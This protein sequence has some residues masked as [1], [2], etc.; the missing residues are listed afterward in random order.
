[1][2]EI[3]VERQ[4]SE[5]KAGRI[6]EANAIAA[7]KK[8]LAESERYLAAQEIVSLIGGRTTPFF[9]IRRET[10]SIEVLVFR[11]DAGKISQKSPVKNTREVS[12]PGK[13]R[14]DT[15][16]Q[17]LGEFMGLDGGKAD[18]LI[19]Y[20]NSFDDKE[21]KGVR[22]TG[23]KVKTGKD[24]EVGSYLKLTMDHPVNVMGTVDDCLPIRGSYRISGQFMLD[25]PKKTYNG[26]ILH[27]GQGQR[28]GGEV[29]GSAKEGVWQTFSIES[30]ALSPTDRMLVYFSR[31][32]AKTGQQGLGDSLLFADLKVEILDR[33]SFV[34]RKFSPEGEVDRTEEEASAQPL[35]FEDRKIL[36]V[37]KDND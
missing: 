15:D 30:K 33:R 11:D 31:D 3:L 34:V 8:Q 10:D 28:I 36:D 2:L 26:L 5:T 12:G 18:P 19:Y 23:V 9:Q 7:T 4:I 24:D 14:G 25:T 16:A 27:H 32:P 35:F 22:W 17:T 21:S 6:D 20:H 29:I 37:S 1:M 13:E